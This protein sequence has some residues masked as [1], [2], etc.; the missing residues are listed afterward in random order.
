M[1]SKAFLL[2]VP[3]I[4]AIVPPAMA[5]PFGPIRIAVN[6]Q[7]YVG[8]NCPVDL[9]FTGTIHF[10]LPHP[11]GFVFNYH[12]ERSDGAKSQVHVARPGP[13]ERSMVVRERWRIGARGRTHDVSQTLFVNSGNT[14]LSEGSQTVHVECR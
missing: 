6:H 5:E 12:W 9:L 7:Q 2:A 1:L 14:H 10:T 3:A 13:N 4:L 11:K 8:R